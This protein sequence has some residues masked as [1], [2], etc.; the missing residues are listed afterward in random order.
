MTETRQRVVGPPSSRN[1]RTVRTAR[2]SDRKDQ[3]AEAAAVAFGRRGYHAVGLSDIAAEVGISAPALYR[4]FPNKYALFAHVA[5]AEMASLVA[6][7]TDPA[8]VPDADADADA[9]ADDHAD[10]DAA[11]VLRA[12]TRGTVAHRDHGSLYRW[13]ARF[14]DDTDRALLRD[15]TRALR[16]CLIGPLR[17]ARPEL[18]ERDA[19]VLTAGALGVVASVTTHDVSD[20]RLE[21]VLV[22]LATHLLTTPL[23]PEPDSDDEATP[24][25]PGP[26]PRAKRE[27]LVTEALKAFDRLGYHSATLEE[28]GGAVG[29]NASSVYR[30]FPTKAALLTAGLER[31]THQID[32]VTEAALVDAAGPE[33]AIRALTAAYVRLWFQRPEVMSVYAT[34]VGNVPAEH[35]EDLRQAQRDH[36]DEWVCL[37]REVRPTLPIALAKLRVQ[38]ALSV[39][40][41]VGRLLHFDPRPSARARVEAL[42]VAV[43]LAP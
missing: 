30:Y 18:T 25:H 33:A 13:E 24:W 3:I 43:L 7:A 23:P 20:E 9:D 21:D 31:C 1:G 11:R 26:R 27:L 17:R 22:G 14:L 41:D 28:I 35:R 15:R 37:V 42:A 34:Q 4:H 32:A 38:A 40:V 12:I 36:L 5:V 6:V 29:L 16:A 10:A 2:P 19:I 8:T 39:V